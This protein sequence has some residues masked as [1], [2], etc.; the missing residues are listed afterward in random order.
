MEEV[1]AELRGYP[2]FQ[3]GEDWLVRLTGK[4]EKI[5]GIIFFSS[6]PGEKTRLYRP[7]EDLFVGFYL[8]DD[9]KTLRPGIPYFWDEIKRLCEETNYQLVEKF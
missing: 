5:R 3:D 8:K 7:E 2:C 1:R 6:I 4:D 9:W